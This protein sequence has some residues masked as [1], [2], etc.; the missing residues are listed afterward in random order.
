MKDK[1]KT[2]YLILDFF[3]RTEQ[4]LFIAKFRIDLD[5]CFIIISCN[6]VTQQA[7]V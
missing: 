6:K 2:A 5:V 1:S 7:D 4:L 3:H